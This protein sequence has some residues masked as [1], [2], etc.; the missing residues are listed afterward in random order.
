MT[1]WQRVVAVLAGV[2]GLIA[3]IGGLIGY[4]SKGSVASLVAGGL[5]GCLL[6]AAAALVPQR[7]KLGLIGALVISLALTGRFVSAAAKAG[8]STVALVMITG[9]LAVLVAAAIA[10]AKSPTRSAL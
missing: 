6:L 2:Y 5:S 7:P 8:P 9:G 1:T 3:L 4:L 10:L